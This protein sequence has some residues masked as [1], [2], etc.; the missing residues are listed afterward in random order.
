MSLAYWAMFLDH[1]LEVSRLQDADSICADAAPGSLVDTWCKWRTTKYLG[2]YEPE[3]RIYLVAIPLV[4]TTSGTILF[5][6]GVQNALSWVSLFFGYG[7]ISVALTAM[8]TITLAY[9]SDCALSV[10][11]DVLLLVNGL[12]NIVAFGFLYGVIPWVDSVGYTS[13]FGTMAGIFAGIVGVGAVLL[14]M[15]G[16]SV[17]HVSAQ[18]KVILE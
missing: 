18:W 14:I 16:A 10:N 5:G 17:R 2:V 6:Y 4:I 11:S 13:S 9:L 12:K 8:P 7:M 15:Y 1:G 3:S